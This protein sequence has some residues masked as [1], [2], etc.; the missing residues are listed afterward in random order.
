[1]SFDGFHFQ[2]TRM[3]EVVSLIYKLG[4]VFSGQKKQDKSEKT[5]LSCEVTLSEQFTKHFMGD[6]IRLCNINDS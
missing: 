3:N 6:L 4:A 2:T 5:V 1:M